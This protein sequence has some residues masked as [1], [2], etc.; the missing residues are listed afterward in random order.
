MTCNTD[1]LS[2]GLKQV[3]G[4]L[5]RIAPATCLSVLVDCFGQSDRVDELLVEHGMQKFND[6]LQRRFIVV[7]KDD[8]EMTGLG[9]GIGHGIVF[10]D[11]LIFREIA[12]DGSALDKMDART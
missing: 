11:E 8:L 10:L 2:R 1:A 3:G 12:L 6:E 5:A 4:D 9:K 7:V